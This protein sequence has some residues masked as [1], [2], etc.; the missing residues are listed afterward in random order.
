MKCKP[1]TVSRRN[2]MLHDLANEGG[3][4]ALKRAAED[5][6]GWRHREWM[7]KT[8]SVAKV[9]VGMNLCRQR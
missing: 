6:Q 9:R 7:S 1:T 3:Y 8:C 2:Q 5:R 4:V